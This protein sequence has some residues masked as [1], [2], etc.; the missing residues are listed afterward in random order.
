MQ[1]NPL[2]KTLPIGTLINYNNKIYKSTT[3]GI[4]NYRILMK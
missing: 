4:L 1:P 3:I 2:P